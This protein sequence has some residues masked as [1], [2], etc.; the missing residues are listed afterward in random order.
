MHDHYL[1]ANPYD[2][3][4]PI[5][6]RINYRLAESFSISRDQAANYHDR[7]HQDS[8]RRVSEGYCDFCNGIVGIIPIIYGINESELAFMKK[9]Q[10]EGRIIIGDRLVKPDS[11]MAM[12][13]CKVCKTPLPK[14]GTC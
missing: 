9:A 11:K 2:E 5:Y 8:P 12:F 10:A 13:G 1:K 14:Y 7:Y 4:D 3:G 6:Y